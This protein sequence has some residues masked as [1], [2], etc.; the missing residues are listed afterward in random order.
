MRLRDKRAKGVHL[1]PIELLVVLLIAAAGLVPLWQFY[2]TTLEDEPDDPSQVVLG[3][4][5][6]EEHCAACHGA[7]LEGEQLQDGRADG[8]HPPP[9]NAN[10]HL[11][12]HSD[13]RLFE[14]VK[15]AFDNSSTERRVSHA[16]SSPRLSDEQVQTVL[17][18]V[19]SSWPSRIRTHQRTHTRYG[20]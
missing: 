20:Q 3:R 19:K 14:L 18:Y 17:A 10:G 8:Q 2:G 11:W 15:G 13:E 9:L 16:L 7:N 5:V 12:H 4:L 6:Y 1:R